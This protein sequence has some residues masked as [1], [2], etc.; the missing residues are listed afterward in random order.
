[1]AT[2]RNILIAIFIGILFIFSSPAFSQ[3]IPPLDKPVEKP[4][5]DQMSESGRIQE[6]NDIK[7]RE[8]PPIAMKITPIIPM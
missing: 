4:Q 5:I 2:I 6:R 3:S 1:M 8:L 7:R